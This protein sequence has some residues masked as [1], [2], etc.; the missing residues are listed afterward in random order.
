MPLCTNAHADIVAQCSSRRVLKEQSY[1][2]RG[3]HN[4]N[5]STSK[6]SNK[7]DNKQTSTPQEGPKETPL[8]VSSTQDTIIA[9]TTSQAPRIVNV[10]AIQIACTHR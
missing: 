8:P 10:A 3:N 7:N 2:L 5:S 6:N 9:T 1:K 4:N